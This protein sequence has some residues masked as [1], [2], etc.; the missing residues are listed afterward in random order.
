MTLDAGNVRVAVTGGIYV[1]PTATTIPTDP[2]T[3]LDAAFD[4]VGYIGE[5]GIT[6]SHGTETSDI[7]AWQNGAV[8]RRVQ[9]SHALTFAFTMIETNPTAL[10]LFYGNYE[11]GGVGTP[12]V[13]EVTGE[14]LDRQR[15]VLHVI[16][17]DDL[18][19]IVVP[20][21]QVTERGDVVYANGQEIGRQ[22]TIT[23]YPDEDEVKAYIYLETE[24]AS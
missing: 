13:V 21:G 2:T 22:V 7:R 17:G 5:D 19:R 12:A 3:E 20:D 24:G 15:F 16:D 10:E 23:C 18:I 14:Q 4:E 9:T 11:D 8:V 1:A 6:E